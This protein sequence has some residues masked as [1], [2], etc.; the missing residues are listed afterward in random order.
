[1]RGRSTVGVLVCCLA[2]LALLGCSD[3]SGPKTSVTASDSACQL[4]ATTL[5]KGDNSFAIRNS[6]TKTTE[7]YVYG[8]A[9]GGAFTKVVE[10]KE[11]I[12][13][14]TSATLK[15]ELEPGTYEVACKPGE[16]GDG[17]RTR[18]TVK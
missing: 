1:M 2:P 8:K 5:G 10:E 6:G 4:S 9:A 18:I 12:G 11:H 15:A 3:T 16:K 17:I 13:P 7:V 14:G